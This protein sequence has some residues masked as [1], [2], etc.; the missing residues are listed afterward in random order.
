MRM[1][2][3]FFINSEDS[4]LLKSEVNTEE[5]KEKQIIWQE[6]LIKIAEERDNFLIMS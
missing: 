4:H 2:L 3:E 5:Y 1:I 6:D